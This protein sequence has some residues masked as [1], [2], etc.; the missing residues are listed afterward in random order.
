[1]A[2]GTAWGAEGG[3]GPAA[4]EGAELPAV[5]FTG[6]VIIISCEPPASLAEITQVFVCLGAG[7]SL[8]S[9]FWAGVWL[10]TLPFPSSTRLLPSLEVMVTSAIRGFQ[11]KN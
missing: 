5:V 7:V 2:A 10:I 3:E 8:E 9:F 11:P 6:L 1:M 4:P